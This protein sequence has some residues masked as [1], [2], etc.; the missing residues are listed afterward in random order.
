MVETDFGEV[1]LIYFNY[2]LSSFTQKFPEGSKVFVSGIMT[3][4]DGKYTIVHPDFLTSEKE[5]IPEFEPIYP[6]IQNIKSGAFSRIIHSILGN[7]PDLPEW[8]DDEIIN[9]LFYLRS[10]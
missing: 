5:K 2:H 9:P 3:Q 8:I 6:M 4:N 7:L 10:N 1:E